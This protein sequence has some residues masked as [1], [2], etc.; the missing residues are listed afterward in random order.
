MCDQN[1]AHC[2]FAFPTAMHCAG[3]YNRNDTP[4][5]GPNDLRCPA[6]VNTEDRPLRKYGVKPVLIFSVTDR[7]ITDAHVNPGNL[8]AFSRAFGPEP[9]GHKQEGHTHPHKD[10]HCSGQNQTSPDS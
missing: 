6:C 4:L 1:S 8:N 9:S 3:I 7:A 5:P 2:R 10:I